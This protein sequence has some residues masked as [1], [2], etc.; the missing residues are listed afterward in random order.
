MSMLVT[1]AM[2]PMFNITTGNWILFWFTNNLWK[3]GVSGAPL[4]PLSKSFCLKLQIT[5]FF[6]N[7]ERRLPSPNCLEIFSFA[8]W[9]IVC[10]CN[11][12]KSIFNLKSLIISPTA[13]ALNRVIFFSRT[14]DSPEKFFK[15]VVINAECRIVSNKCVL[16]NIF[17]IFFL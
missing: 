17:P 13:F 14:W 7:F 15:Y 9:K 11:P 4:P 8:L 16:M 12:I 2:P 3:T 10:P 6:I 1:F 5:L